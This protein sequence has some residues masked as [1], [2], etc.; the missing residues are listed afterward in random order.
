M[1]RACGARRSGVGRIVSSIYRHIANRHAQHV[2]PACVERHRRAA[3]IANGDEHPVRAA[4]PQ[5]HR[6]LRRQYQDERD[7]TRPAALPGRSFPVEGRGEKT[8]IVELRHS[9]VLSEFRTIV[10]IQIRAGE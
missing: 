7:A 1:A 10:T 2:L 4:P 6:F 3:R 9:Y 8:P 5:L